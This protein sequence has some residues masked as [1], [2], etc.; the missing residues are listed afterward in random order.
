MGSIRP[1]SAGAVLLAAASTL[2]FAQTPERQPVFESA[3]VK[4]AAL[5][6]IRN[7][8]GGPGTRNPGQIS[9]TNASLQELIVLA[10]GLDDPKRISGPNWLDMLRYDITAKLPSGTTKIQLQ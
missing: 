7:V 9:Y 5:H 6:S 8:V 10:Y 1:L 3:S 4:P 2:S